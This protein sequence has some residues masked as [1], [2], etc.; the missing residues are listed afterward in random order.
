MSQG[1]H[2]R[3]SVLIFLY[4]GFHRLRILKFVHRFVPDS[5][6]TDKRNRIQVA[7]FKLRVA[8]LL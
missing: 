6:A 2:S 5:G 3:L 8:L 4:R 1:L 7:E